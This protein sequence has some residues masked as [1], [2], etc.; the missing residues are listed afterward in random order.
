MDRTSRPLPR[1]L[2]RKPLVGKRDG[3]LKALLRANE[4]NPVSSLDDQEDQLT[5]RYQVRAEICLDVVTVP[6]KRL[7]D[8]TGGHAAAEVY[9]GSTSLSPSRRCTSD[10][11]S[12]S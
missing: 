11:G 2:S 8:V 6:K 5:T 1:V 7:R 10:R 9:L 12:P 4:L 3:G